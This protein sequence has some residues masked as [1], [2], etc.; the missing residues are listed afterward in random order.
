MKKTLA[1]QQYPDGTWSWTLTSILGDSL[2]KAEHR[3][4]NRVAIINKKSQ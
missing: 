4:G 2:S 3:F 1:P